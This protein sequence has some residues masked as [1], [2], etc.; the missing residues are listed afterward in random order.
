MTL[1]TIIQ[2]PGT[3]GDQLSNA[4]KAAYPDDVYVLGNGAWIVSDSVTA[5][6]VSDKIGISEG[7]NGSA[8]VVEVAS[9]FGRANPSIWSWMKAKWEQSPSG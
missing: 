6:D 7:D 8:I 5:R 2:Q 4:V 9:Y 3:I 1:F